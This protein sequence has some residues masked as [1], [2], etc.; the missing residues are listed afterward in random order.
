MSLISSVC[1]GKAPKSQDPAVRNAAQACVYVR[2]VSWLK[3]FQVRDAGLLFKCGSLSELNILRVIFADNP[4]RAAHYSDIKQLLSQ[5]AK[6]SVPI[7]NRLNTM[8]EI[9]E[10]PFSKCK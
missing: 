2:Q 1:V 3:L 9:A 6:C 10:V 5:V 7:A 8:C 4:L